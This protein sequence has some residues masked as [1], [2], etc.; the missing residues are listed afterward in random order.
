MTEMIMQAFRNGCRD[1]KRIISRKKSGFNPSQDKN[2]FFKMPERFLFLASFCCNAQAQSVQ[3]DEASR[4]FLV[5][6]TG[7]V[8]KSR[9][10]RVEQGIGLGFAAD[11]DDV[12]LVQF[13]ADRTVDVF[14]C[15]ISFCRATRSGAHQ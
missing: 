9:D 15:M 11:N 6:C 12:A 4:V 1:G 13:Q 8:F 3:F 10:G 7:I 14:L 2:R 5:V